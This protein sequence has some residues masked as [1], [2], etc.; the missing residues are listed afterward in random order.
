[1]SASRNHKIFC[2]T[3]TLYF[4]FY[5]YFAHFLRV[6]TSLLLLLGLNISFLSFSLLVSF[7]LSLFYFCRSL[8]I[9]ISF[10]VLLTHP[11]SLLPSL[12]FFALSGSW[13]LSHLSPS[14]LLRSPI[15]SRI[16]RSSLL[17]T[18]LLLALHLHW[19]SSLLAS[20]ARF[21][22]LLDPTTSHLSSFSLSLSVSFS[23]L[24]SLSPRSLHT[25]S[26]SSPSS[27]R[28]L[29]VPLSLLSVL[30]FLSHEAP[31]RVTK[32][33]LYE[34]IAVRLLVLASQESD[35]TQCAISQRSL[36]GL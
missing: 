17:P 36:L 21:P 28:F 8:W 34:T 22:R 19:A 25:L 26:S 13:Y 24:F 35:H 11:E 31:R 2:F 9:F 5:V 16:L 20:W 7:R 30:C 14:C 33:A 3:F 12:V 18:R 4:Y 29:L 27:S 23:S 32:P 15:L 10:L 6:H 1:M